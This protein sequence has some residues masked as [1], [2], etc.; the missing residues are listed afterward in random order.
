M[1]VK[2]GK[3]KMTNAIAERMKEMDFHHINECS[4]CGWEAWLREIEYGDVKSIVGVRRTPAGY[5]YRFDFIPPDEDGEETWGFNGAESW[6]ALGCALEM[7]C[8]LRGA[9]RCL[10]GSIVRRSIRKLL[11]RAV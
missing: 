7:W 6:N 2:K 8:A 1:E 4:E 11:I 3:R 9:R 5:E 10:E